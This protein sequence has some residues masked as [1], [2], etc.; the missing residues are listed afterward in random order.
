[1]SVVGIDFGNLNSV[2]AVARNKGIDI[3]VNEVSNRLTPSLVCL[4]GKSRHL[5]E[6]A[7]TMEISNSSNTVSCLKRLL[8]L[9]FT[10]PLVEKEKPFLSCE[11]VADVDGRVAVRVL[12]PDND[13]FA[14]EVDFPRGPDGKIQL[15]IVQIVAMYL[16][17]LKV[18]AEAALE[19]TVCDVV[20]AVPSSYTEPQR[21]AM[22]DAA[23]IANLNVLRLLNDTTASALAY[24]IP[25]TD[26]PESSD[27]VKPR[28]VCL[29]DIG[30][31][32]TQAAIVAFSKG[33][34][35]V[36][37]IGYDRSL[38][39]RD[40]D[41]CMLEHYARFFSTKHKID[42]L[43][44]KKALYRLRAACEKAKK[45][46][47]TNSKAILSVENI[48][49]DFDVSTEV[50][51][52]EM[53]E[54]WMHLISRIDAPIR[55]AISQAGIAPNDIFC[56]ETI[57]GGS[58]V[59]AVRERLS[60]LFGG[61]ELSSTLNPDEAVARGSAFQCAI[62]SPTFKVK[63][64]SVT[65]IS[66]FPISLSW[67]VIPEDPEDKDVLLFPIGNVVPSTKLLTFEHRKQDFAVEARYFGADGPI[68][69]RYLVQNVAVAE[70]ALIKLKVRLNPNG[71]INVEQV[72]F[73]EQV[74]EAQASE[75]QESSKIKLVKKG[76]L[77]FSIQTCSLSKATL[78][79]YVELEAS[80]YE[81]D[82]LVADT[83]NAKNALEEYIYD[84]RGRLEGDLN[85]FVDENLKQG[86]LQDLSKLE[87]WLYDL[88]W[89]ET[90]SV[91]LSKLQDMKA[92]GEPIVKRKHEFE[93]YSHLV[94][95]YLT[96][97]EMLLTQLSSVEPRHD[98]IP[99]EERKPLIDLVNSRILEVRKAS[100]T[101][102]AIPKTNEVTRNADLGGLGTSA[103]LKSSLESLVLAVSS[104][105]N[106]AKPKIE[107][108]APPPTAASS[109]Q[110]TTASATSPPDSNFEVTEMD[111]D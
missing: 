30:E 90:K 70:G 1:M 60:T 52:A 19:R 105:M 69:G 26:L 16:G 37:G 50:S 55:E 106:R 109:P 71:V 98:H 18:I 64:F 96:T 73:Y 8:G 80:M 104:V 91:Y 7:K 95:K 67:E 103:E 46:L 72:A 40:F 11:L 23:V 53:E 93:E 13:S 12:P 42:I 94:Q 35:E 59:P 4:A 39:G 15:S 36:K 3:I 97:A 9:M 2:V 107:A 29:V 83:E 108:A 86:F 20:I 66:P 81:A 6:S 27:G 51:R 111:L 41:L 54:I 89:N 75:S 63:D 85:E 28:Y 62:L 45:I 57:G 38:G 65:E 47:S 76:E 74:T 78:D 102:M 100:E 79:K 21:R 82:K 34:L 92:I 56:V 5:G 68:I 25:K 10:D 44:N 32:Q 17:K 87:S 24:G 49:N 31:S 14:N 101:R 58:R 48:M 77:P 88:G 61:K 99:S 43:S 110:D 33:K 22:L 84:M